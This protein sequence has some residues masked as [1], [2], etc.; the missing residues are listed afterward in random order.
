M[1]AL[2]G[3]LHKEGTTRAEARRLAARAEVRRGRG[4][5]RYFVYK[6]Q[7]R[8]GEFSL[9]LQFKKVEVDRQ[10]IIRTLETILETLRRDG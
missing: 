1:T 6:L 8:G 5:P 2:I 3:R 4:R 10:E 9:A 7:S